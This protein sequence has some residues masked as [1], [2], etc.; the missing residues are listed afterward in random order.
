MAEDPAVEEALVEVYG[1]DGAQ[2]L[3]EQFFG[4][5]HHFE[6]YIAMLR[7]ELSSGGGL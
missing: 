4:A 2:E 3:F 1:E 5:F 7:P 6:N